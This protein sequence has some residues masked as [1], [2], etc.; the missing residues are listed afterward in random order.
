MSCGIDLSSRS[1]GPAARAGSPRRTCSSAQPKGRRRRARRRRPTVGGPE[2][3]PVAEGR[4]RALRR[5]RAP[6]AVA[7]Q[8]DQRPEPARN[9]VTI[10][11]VTHNDEADITE[12]E[13]FRKRTNGEQSDVK[14]TM[15]ALLVKAVVASLKAFPE[16]STRRSTATSWCSSATTTSASRPTRRTASSSR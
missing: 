11:H 3:R 16:S 4:L 2:P 12:L 1:A 6:P 7:D 8:E 9:W 13:A 10:P 5:G 14:V 15:V